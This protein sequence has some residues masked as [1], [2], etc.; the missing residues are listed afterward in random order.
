MGPS[1]PP[2]PE[3]IDQNSGAEILVTELEKRITPID[4]NISRKNGFSIELWLNRRIPQ[5][6]GTITKR[7]LAIPIIWIKRSDIIA[8]GAPKILVIVAAFSEFQDASEAL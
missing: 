5:K 1:V 6:E 2:S 3:L 7:Q 4:K 8:P